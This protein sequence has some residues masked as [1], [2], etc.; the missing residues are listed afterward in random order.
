MVVLGGGVVSY[1]RGTPLTTHVARQ[2]MKEYL[3]TECEFV[4]RMV[5]D[6]APLI[7]AAIKDFAASGERESL[8]TYDVA[9]YTSDVQRGLEIKNLRDLKNGSDPLSYIAAAIK[10]FAAFGL[11]A[12]NP[13]P[14]TRNRASGPDPP[15]YGS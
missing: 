5:P 1:E 9:S 2:V 13:K 14:E 4:T 11:H 8:W 3:S 12:R 7:A 6:E 10:D 15:P